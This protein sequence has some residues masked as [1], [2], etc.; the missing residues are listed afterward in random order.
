[1]VSERKR[2]N[3]DIKNIHTTEHR[4]GPG[5]VWLGSGFHQVGN[6]FYHGISKEFQNMKSVVV[7]GSIF[8]NVHPPFGSHL[9]FT[10]FRTTD[11]TTKWN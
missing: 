7:P 4:P 9:S 11:E 10:M 3:N 2:Q 1:L 5:P 6:R 8:I